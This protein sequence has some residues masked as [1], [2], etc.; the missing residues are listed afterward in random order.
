[1]LWVQAPAFRTLTLPLLSVQENRAPV[2]AK[3]T[4]FLGFTPCPTFHGQGFAILILDSACFQCFFFFLRTQKF[5]IFGKKE[6][7]LEIL[8]LLFLFSSFNNFCFFLLS[9]FFL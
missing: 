9:I 1:M 2:L 7:E 4:H 5:G 8:K 6:N 3:L